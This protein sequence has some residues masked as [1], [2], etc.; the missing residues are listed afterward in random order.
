M[1]QF[2][3]IC[4]NNSLTTMLRDLIKE[5]GLYT[6]ANLL[7]K[8]IGL[9]LIP[10]YTAYFTTADYGMIDILAVFGGI[11]STLISLQLNQ[12]MSR[13]IA[14]GETEDAQKRKI[15]ST[16]IIIITFIYLGFGVFIT[17]YPELF[18][19]ILSNPDTKV[20]IELIQYAIYATILSGILYLLGVY[21]RALRRVK[22][23]TFLSFGFALINT[24]LMIYLI[25]NLGLGIKGI[26]LSTIII[27]PVFILITLYLLRK[28]IMFF[29]GKKEFLLIFKFSVPLIPAALSY[30][31]MNTIDRIY[32]KDM[33]SFDEAGI[34]GIA[35]KFSSIITIIITGFTMA[36]NPIVFENH[37]KKESKKEIER[38]F[39]YFFVFGT[40]GLI[41]LS[42][43]SYETLFIFTNSTFYPA[44]IIMP[45]MYLSVLVTGLAMFSPGIN[46]AG[47]TTIG[48]IVIIL[49]S[50]LN[51]V[52][53]YSFIIWFGL[54]GAAISTLI[55]VS[56]FYVV[57]FI[58][59]TKHYPIF[60]NFKKLI[61]ILSLNLGLIVLGAYFINFSF[62]INF[63]LKILLI[64]IYCTVIYF[65]HLKTGI[66]KIKKLN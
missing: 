41:V 61:P 13:F 16:T 10:F 36:M 62:W 47:K 66:I 24:L 34:Y 23:F 22:E 39:Q 2:D 55:C 26:Y 17:F 6:I 43:F 48:A 37:Q 42:L 21:L 46:I 57:Y 20:P 7:T 64:I 60:L 38:I 32:I 15:A 44:A 28:E 19:D 29:V 1:H 9:L 51:L 63:T 49:T 65:T 18:V 45:V 4:R 11:V 8:G 50:A 53:N 27:S 40:I 33:L 35:F 31:L 12:G 3:Y 5:G 52:L 14:D 30:L 56:I 58:I 25:L 54:I 59:S